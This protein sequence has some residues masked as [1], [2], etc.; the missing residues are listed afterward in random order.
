M[1][2]FD[3]ASPFTMQFWWS[4]CGVLE[5]EMREGN[6][7]KFVKNSS[8]DKNCLIYKENK[9]KNTK[10]FVKNRFYK[11]IRKS[12]PCWRTNVANFESCVRLFVAHFPPQ[13]VDKAK[14]NNFYWDATR[15]DVR[16]ELGIFR[17][18]QFTL[19]TRTVPNEIFSDVPS[20]RIEEDET[21]NQRFAVEDWKWK[22]EID[23]RL[24]MF[25]STCHV[26]REIRRTFGNN[27][28]F[29]KIPENHFHYHIFRRTFSITNIC[30]RLK[31][32]IHKNTH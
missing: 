6:I 3:V 29:S 17:V 4:N 25:H 9:K 10:K 8:L 14:S 15:I 31:F 26:L 12:S 16:S 7:K 18:R 1:R 5:G 21:R 2:F 19:F 11:K 28:Q 13:Q 23:N 24:E 32:F 27:N 22:H 20:R 30:T